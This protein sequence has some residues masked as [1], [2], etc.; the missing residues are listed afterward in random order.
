MGDN[1]LDD[2]AA[3]PDIRFDEVHAGLPGLLLGS[4]TQGDQVGPGAVLVVARANTDRRREGLS[5]A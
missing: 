3:D 4:G 5:M 1:S 2:V